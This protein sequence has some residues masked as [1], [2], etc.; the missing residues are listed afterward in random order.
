MIPTTS[1]AIP[2][3]M[4]VTENVPEDV[5]M[6]EAATTSPC[7]VEDS[8]NIPPTEKVTNQMLY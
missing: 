8:T 2:E 4:T 6:Y 7:G 3:D 1:A 5:L